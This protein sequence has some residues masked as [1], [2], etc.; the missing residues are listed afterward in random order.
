MRESELA[1][2]K[3]NPKRVAMIVWQISTYLN[4]NQITGYRTAHAARHGPR[5]YCRR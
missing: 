3:S 5:P 2:H 4:G 1:L